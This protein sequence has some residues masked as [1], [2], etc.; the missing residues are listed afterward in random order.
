MQVIR[1]LFGIIVLTGGIGWIGLH[2][3]LR[4]FIVSVG[5][6]QQPGPIKMPANLP[7]PVA[8]Y[9]ETAIGDP[10][11]IIETALV[12]GRARLVINGIPVPARVKFYHCA[13]QAY[14]HYLQVGWFGTPLLSVNER[15]LDGVAI[16]DIPGNTI[17]DN[18]QTNSAANL[19]LWAETVWLPSVWFTDERVSWEAVDDTTAQLVVPYADEA[20]V[21][22]VRFDPTTYLITELST[23]RYQNPDSTERT[24]WTA[25]MINWKK[26]NQIMIP[27]VCELRWANDKPWA[28]WTIDDVI[29][30][31]DVSDRFAEFGSN[32]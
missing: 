20:E 8:R 1:I 11:P 25:T 29:Y 17:R 28:H 15:Y 10:I 2:I 27:S 24:L 16:I 7:A 12:L 32:S 30:N 21:F 14:Y 4:R 5:D 19:G 31:L 23:M 26:I 9:V 22:T 3:K 13:G 6:K 18:V